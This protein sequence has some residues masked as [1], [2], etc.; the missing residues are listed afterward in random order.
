MRRL[1]QRNAFLAKVAKLTALGLDWDPANAGG[2]RPDEA[3]WEAQLARLAAYRAAHG[4]CN[5]PQGWPEDAR[6]SNWVGDPP[7]R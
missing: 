4:D 7:H 3:K 5:V 6:L 2:G 1:G